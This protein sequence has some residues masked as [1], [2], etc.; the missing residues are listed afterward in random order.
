[1]NESDDMGWVQFGLILLLLVGSVYIGVAWFV[2]EWRNPLC[3]EL[4][5]YR[6]FGAV[7]RFEK[8]P[9]YQRGQR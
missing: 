9:E 4:A 5:L 3:N 8:V 6:D 7:V 2:F 1:M